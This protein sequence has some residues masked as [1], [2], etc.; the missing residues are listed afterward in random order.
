MEHMGGNPSEKVEVHKGQTDQKP[1]AESLASE[2]AYVIL[3][4]RI[5][6]K[7]ARISKR[8]TLSDM[9]GKQ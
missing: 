8:L 7:D 9:G 2:I 5:R 3:Q 6:L 4:N 1:H